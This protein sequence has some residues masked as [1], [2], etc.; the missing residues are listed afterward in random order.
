VC[1]GFG[2]VIGFFSVRI[3]M[4]SLST[5][6]MA[7]MVTTSA[8]VGFLSAVVFLRQNKEKRMAFEDAAERMSKQLVWDMRRKYFCDAQSV[9]YANSDPILVLQGNGQFLIDEKGTKFLDSR[10]NPACVGW[11]RSEWVAAVSR[12]LART[13]SNTRYLHPFPALLAEELVAT[14]PKESGLCKVFFVNSGSEANDLALRLA[15]AFSKG[16]DVITVDRAYH[17][18][19]EAILGISPYKFSG[20]GGS[21]RP[22]T[23]QVVPCPDLY[24]DRRHG[25][26]LQ[27]F[28][29]R[30][31]NHVENACRKVEE[32]GRKV[33]A[34]FI[35]SGM[36][37][38]GVI[39]P[40]QG[41]LREIYKMV[42]SRGAVC[43]ADEVQVGMARFGESFWGFEQQD[44]N[45]DIVTIAKPLGNGFPLAAV[46]CTAE[47]A[48]N[49]ANGMEYFNT[50][51]GNAAA[52]A[53]GLAVLEIIKRDG[54][55]A[56]AKDVGKYFR[57][58]L[59]ALSMDKSGALIGDVRGS[60]LFIGVEFVSDRDEKTPATK[61]VSY[62]ATQMLRKYKIL[63][64]ID[65]KFDN[66]IVIKPPLIYSRKDADY[67]VD[68][69][70]EILE[71]IAAVDLSKVQHT[72]T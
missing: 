23:T 69:L 3:Q 57:D 59:R 60:G 17:G 67:F 42:H 50:F 34:F 58:L 9:S 24:R 16:T 22:V 46:V 27:S 10:N 36:S 31:T 13:N 15:K 30:F 63:S 2:A 4:S 55:Q 52:C 5:P 18:H 29:R 43:V 62:I 56:H 32:E 72:P 19:T 44:V 7:L 12:Q 33:A 39:L 38:A 51:G 70:R 6:A 20:K 64:T 68:A 65:G 61:E 40:P 21:G 28:T 11:Q 47:I 8:I 25:E 14:M 53:A 45:P 71:N 48:E 66:V 35:E 37:V 1:A 26:S 54:L 41:Y 49:F